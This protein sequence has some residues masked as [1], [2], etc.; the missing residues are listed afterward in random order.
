LPIELPVRKWTQLQQEIDGYL[1]EINR[2]VFDHS[3]FVGL[4]ED[5]F[6]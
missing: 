3:V 4:A 5:V 2:H 6:L 1:Y